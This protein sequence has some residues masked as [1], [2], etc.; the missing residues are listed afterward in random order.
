MTLIVIQG[1]DEFLMERAA[2]D[3]SR[4]LLCRIPTKI[5]YDSYSSLEY[6]DLFEVKDEC[7]IVN[8]CPDN[9]DISRFKDKNHILI[10]KEGVYLKKSDSIDRIIKIDKLKV[11]GDK[12]DIIRWIIQEGEHLNIDLSRVAGA[13]FLNSGSRLRKI[14]TEIEKLRTIASDGDTISPEVAKSVLCFSAELTPK[15]IIDAM[16]EGKT[17]VCL[18]VYDRLQESGNETGWVLSFLQNFVSQVLRSKIMC[19]LNTKGV[20]ES[21]SVSAYIYN[22][23]ILPHINKWS[24]ESLKTSTQNLF[25][26]E[27][28][29]KLG[30]SISDF[31]LESEIIRLSEEVKVPSKRTA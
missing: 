3:E 31:L 4:S 18:S 26:I 15:N 19:S 13:L 9:L 2:L 16:V 6:S 7:V 8:K 28:N 14:Y 27:Y 5:N 1:E 12:N 25:V 17:N 23:F 10:M 30:R 22:N 11:S 20:Y 29:H 21:L 24:L